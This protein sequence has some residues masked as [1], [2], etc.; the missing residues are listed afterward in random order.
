M[1]I[2]IICVLSLLLGESGRTCLPVVGQLGAKEGS[3]EQ[4]VRQAMASRVGAGS[5]VPQQALRQRGTY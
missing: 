4:L 2:R 1:I 5:R 3:A